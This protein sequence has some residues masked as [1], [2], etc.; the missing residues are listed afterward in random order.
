MRVIMKIH[1]FAFILVLLLLTL[2]VAGSLSAAPAGAGQ[3]GINFT[4]NAPADELAL[5]YTFHTAIWIADKNGKLLK[6]LYVNNELS[7]SQ[8]KDQNVVPE[9]NKQANWDKVDKAK[10]MADGLSAPTPIVGDNPL[11]WDL[12]QVGL[13][14]GTY[15]FC[16]QVHIAEKWNIL[17]RGT[18]TAGSAKQ[19]DLK[20]ETLQTG[21]PSGSSSEELVKIIS[22]TYYPPK[23][24]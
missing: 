8:Y 21:K 24:K 4:F 17:Y 18:F 22:M 12:D 16:M 1:W 11:V 13:Q 6:T 19:E 15:Q 20:F 7:M 5:D 10:A 2:P 3:V 9:W 14:P 23:A